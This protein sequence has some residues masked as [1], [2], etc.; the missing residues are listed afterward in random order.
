MRRESRIDEQ[1]RE[2][3]SRHKSKGSVAS[4]LSS[5]HLQKTGSAFA[6]A[7][8]STCTHARHTHGARAEAFLTQSHRF[9][10]VTSQG[11]A[12]HCACDVVR[13]D[14]SDPAKTV[15]N[16]EFAGQVVDSGEVSRRERKKKQHCATRPPLSAWPF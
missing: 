16:G 11:M 1:T 13:D 8:S 14:R 6:D 10:S 3:R 12:D 9:D 2:E 15:T 7:G 5:A 4:C